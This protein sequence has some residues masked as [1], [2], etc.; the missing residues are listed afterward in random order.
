MTPYLKPDMTDISWGNYSRCSTPGLN[1]K[2]IEDLNYFLFN[3]MLYN[4]RHVLPPTSSENA[5]LCFNYDSRLKRWALLWQYARFS[6]KEARDRQETTLILQ[7]GLH[8]HSRSPWMDTGLPY[9]SAAIFSHMNST[10]KSSLPFI[11][12]MSLNSLILGS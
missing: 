7:C 4:L 6:M 5:P 10:W 12:L 2:K 9:E 8:M 11:S 1:W 3:G